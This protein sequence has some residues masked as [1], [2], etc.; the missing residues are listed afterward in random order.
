MM[1][2]A[3]S[4]LLPNPEFGLFD[5]VHVRRRD[6]RFVKDREMACH[7]NFVLC[8]SFTMRETFK[9]MI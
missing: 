4:V 7:G 5:W 9:L 8:R 3:E 1:M 2:I 6:V